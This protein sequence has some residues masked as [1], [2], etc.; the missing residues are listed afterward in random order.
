MALSKVGGNQIDT[1]SGDLTVDTNTLVVDSTN[2]KVGIGTTS[3][4]YQTTV[5]GSSQSTVEIESGSDTGESRLYFTDPTTTGV[6]TVEYHHNGN[7]MRFQANSAERMRITGD[8]QGGVAIG[9]TD[10]DPTS[11]GTSTRAFLAVQGSGNRGCLALG[12]SSNSGGDVAALRFNNGSNVVASIG[13]DSDSGSTSA[14]KLLFYTNQTHRM[15]ITSGGNI[16]INETN[17]T[18]M[19]SLQTGVS[20][21]LGDLSDYSTKGILGNIHPSISSQSLGSTSVDDVR[22]LGF[23]STYTTSAGGTKPTSYG[24]IRCFEHY[25]GSLNKGARYLSQLAVGHA[26]NPAW[27]ARN[28]NTSDGTSYGTWYQI[29]MTSTSDERSKENVED[30]PDQLAVVKQFQVKEF[31]YIDNADEPRQLGMMAQHVD[32]FAPEYVTKDNE[33]PDIM[34]RI[35]YNKMVPMLVKALQEATTKIETLETEMTALKARVTALEAG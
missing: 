3:P 10:P 5:F 19:L 11:D 34:W 29:D 17:P 21:G 30:A 23:G 18:L 33:D 25:N 20:M 26:N 8:G 27:Y 16:G 13:C 6:G 12:T 7:T 28:S 32:T 15:T 1:V 31:D 24:T 14:G 2:N 9:G 22:N 4:T 35:K